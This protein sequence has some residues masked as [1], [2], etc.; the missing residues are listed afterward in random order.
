MWLGEV[1]D[2]MMYASEGSSHDVYVGVW[3]CVI[4]GVVV[5]CVVLDVYVCDNCAGEGGCSSCF[6]SGDVCGIVGACLRWKTTLLKCVGI[7]SSSY[8]ELSTSQL[9]SP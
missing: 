8:L 4:V 5:V 9:C 6:R 3:L 7:K 1:V 2:N